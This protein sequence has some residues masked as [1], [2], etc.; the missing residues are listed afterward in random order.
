[1]SINLTEPVLRPAAGKVGRPVRVRANFFEVNRIPSQNIPHYDV[2]ID[3][4]STPPAVLKKS[5]AIF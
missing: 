1:M 5:V 4:A 2:T 3:P